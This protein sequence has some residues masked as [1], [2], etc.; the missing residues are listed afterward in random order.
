MSAIRAIRPLLPALLLLL[1]GC[2]GGPPPGAAAGEADRDGAF[3]TFVR[4]EIGFEGASYATFFDVDNDGMRDIVV[5]S[6]SAGVAWFRSPTWERYGITTA[7]EQYIHMAPNDIDGDG[8][9]DLAIASEFALSN[10][11]GGGLISWV[12]NP[13]DPTANGE[14][15]SR[16]I[17]AIPASHRLRWGDV[18]G[19]GT[20]ELLVLPIVG[21][22][23]AAPEYVG[24]SRLTAY[25]IPADPAESWESRVLDD[26]RLEVAH[27]IIAFDWD[28]DGAEDVLTASLAGVFLF[29]PA[30]GAA[31][32]HI[33]AGLEAPR[34]DRG[35]SEV[36]VGSLAGERFVATIDP[37]HG[38]DA[39]IYRSGG[40]GTEPWSRE[41][42]ATEFENGHGLAAA[43]LDGDG[44]DEVVGGGRGGGG[45]LVI[46]RYLPDAGRW[47]RIPLDVGG[48]LTSS[49]EV[50]DIDGDGDLD[51]LAG[52]AG[53]DRVVWFE[54]VP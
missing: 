1:G 8:D 4:H 6:G 17:D 11:T 51:V 14:W 2:E 41:V 46:Y 43:D 34:P 42:I 54:N 28:G 44:Y 33:G 36:A 38:T 49:T 21:I 18:D 13:G 31:P 7:S 37:W 27:G 24:A 53:T 10:S 20:R 9:V 45:T 26:S 22:G 15:R 35:S 23:A 29:T 52:S 5:L 19:D 39:V 32:Q 3:P 40:G 25:R 50:H 30:L 47:E 12:E 16:R 48:V